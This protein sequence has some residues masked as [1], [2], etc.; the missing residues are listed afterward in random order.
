MADLTELNAL[1]R[2]LA[3][4]NGIE[5]LDVIG[6]LCVPVDSSIEV[7]P[8]RE[9]WE[10][11]WVNVN[12]SRKPQKWILYRKLPAPVASDEAAA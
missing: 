9:G 5:H 1:Q 12:L 7:A 4:A 6:N 8:K 10:P 2:A 3:R 11:F